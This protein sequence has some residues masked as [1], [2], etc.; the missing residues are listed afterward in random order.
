[1]LQEGGFGR[2]LFL[3]EARPRMSLASLLGTLVLGLASALALHELGHVLVALLFGGRVERVRWRGLSAQVLASLP[4]RRA[5]VA[6][7]LAGSAMNLLVAGA[8]GA[9][10]FAVGSSTMALAMGLIA[11]MHLLHAA[12]ALVPSGTNDGARLRQL[13]RQDA[14]EGAAG[15]R[16]ER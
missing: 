8:A 16:G 14:R 1:M 11:G 4:S 7:L 6:F 2:P 3:C 15:R 10:A 12:F 5:Q 9:L 13:N